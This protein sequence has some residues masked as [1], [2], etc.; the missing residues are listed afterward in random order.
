M[1]LK[2]VKGT[3]NNEVIHCFFFSLFF[4]TNVFKS[5]CFLGKEQI[6]LQTESELESM[7]GK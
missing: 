4:L 7:F 5:L 2:C 1:I 6:K 3:T